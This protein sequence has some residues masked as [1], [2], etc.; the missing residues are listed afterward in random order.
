[1][2]S[3]RF[4]KSSPQDVKSIILFCN[5]SDRFFI[6][7]PFLSLRN[8][9]IYYATFRGHKEPYLSCVYTIIIFKKKLVV[10]MYS[11][12]LTLLNC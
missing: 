11:S 5:T 1:M 4:E 3:G 12:I 2:L 7:F 6:Y 8:K 9:E 10:K